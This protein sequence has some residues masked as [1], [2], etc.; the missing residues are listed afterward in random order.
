MNKKTTLFIFIIF[1]LLISLSFAETEENRDIIKKTRIMDSNA[2]SLKSKGKIDEAVG[3][4]LKISI[5][6]KKLIS[7]NPENKRYKK[8]YLHYLN[9]TGQIQLRYAKDMAKKKKFDIAS[10]YYNSAIKSF[11]DALLKIP[12]NKTFIQNI[13]YCA[14]YGGIAGFKYLL[15][16][17]GTAPDFT[18]DA[19]NGSKI[20]L[21]NYIGK[22][23]I[24]KFMTAWCPECKKNMLI[25]KQLYNK[26]NKK[27]FKII[28]LS[29]DKLNNWKKRA[30]DK[31]AEEIAKDLP[32]KIGWATK[33]IYYKYGVFR[34][35]PTLF[36][37]DKNL[38]IISKIKSEDRTFEKLS[39]EIEKLL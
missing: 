14:Y 32:F 15:E 30:S 9:Q 10:K 2:R 22:P 16:T 8:N 36:L 21:K 5:I 4:Y 7:E 34:S 35:V 25:M 23:L 33:D 11:K 18:I 6:Y 17:N 37:L 26:Y 31:K 24:L 12:K 13:E 39:T 38:K 3:T 27:G 28:V 29:L 1:F 20:K 19:I